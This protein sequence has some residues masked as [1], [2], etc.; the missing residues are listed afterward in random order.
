MHLCAIH[1][2]IQAGCDIRGYMVWSLLD[3][4]EWSLGYSKRFGIV[5]V[6]Y[7]TQQRTPKD[8]ARWYSS[9]IASHGGA[10]SDPL[11]G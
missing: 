9:V 5:H 6:N 2:A 7:A 10:L 3:N 8:S 11:P 1:A 4:L